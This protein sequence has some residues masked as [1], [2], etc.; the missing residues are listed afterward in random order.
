MSQR[1][2]L[3]TDVP[4][5]IWAAGAHWASALAG[6]DGSRRLR[7]PESHPGDT[8]HAT[9]L[10]GSGAWALEKGRGVHPPR[11][12]RLADKPANAVQHS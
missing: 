9:G 10:L 7:R 8:R 5:S 12:P 6:L 1:R 4:I 11:N 2:D 3:S